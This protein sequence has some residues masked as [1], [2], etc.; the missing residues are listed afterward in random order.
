MT[1]EEFLTWLQSRVQY[2]FREYFWLQTAL[3]TPGY[4]GIKD[5]SEEEVKKYEGNR[6]LAQL[7]DSL[8]PLIVRQEVL[9]VEG[10]PRSKPLTTTSCTLLIFRREGKRRSIENYG[11]REPRHEGEIAWN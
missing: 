6:P 10:G 4:D 5:G 8:I 11:S 7:G 2:V 3:I 1:D 9:F